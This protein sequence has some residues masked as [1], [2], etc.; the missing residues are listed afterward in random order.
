[1]PTSTKT[2]VKRGSKK[3]SFADSHNG[4]L[5]L[6]SGPDGQGERRWREVFGYE[7]RKVAR[8]GEPFIAREARRSSSDSK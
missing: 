4:L 3:G 5:P 6:F 7:P 1:M 2:S 8:K